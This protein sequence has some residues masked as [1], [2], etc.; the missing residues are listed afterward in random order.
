MN[1]LIELLIV[2]IIIILMVYLVKFLPDDVP[3]LKTIVTV[4]SVTHTAYYRVASCI[5]I[6][7][8]LFPLCLNR[9]VIAMATINKTAR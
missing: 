2:V 6:V 9:S 7:L 3:G 1:T 8:M 4:A 5:L